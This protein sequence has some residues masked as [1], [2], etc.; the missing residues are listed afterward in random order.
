ML[1]FKL[2]LVNSS[3]ALIA[4][5]TPDTVQASRIPTTRMVARVLLRS[6]VPKINAHKR[7]AIPSTTPKAA[8]NARTL[9]IQTRVALMAFCRVSFIGL[10]TSYAL[11]EGLRY[12]VPSIQMFCSSF[13]LMSLSNIQIPAISTAGMMGSDIF[14]TSPDTGTSSPV[15]CD[16]CVCTGI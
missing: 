13:P 1:I 10:W 3:F 7:R 16:S 14:F 4:A 11:N 2:R 9:F 12:E 5:N 6:S 15:A 8:R